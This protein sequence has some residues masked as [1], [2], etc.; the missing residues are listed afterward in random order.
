M[1]AD[2]GQFTTI[3]GDEVRE[4]KKCIVQ[5][6]TSENYVLR[7]SGSLQYEIRSLLKLCIE[8]PCHSS[9]YNTG[10]REFQLGRKHSLK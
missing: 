4:G 10:R 7:I 5:Q 3:A 2:V 9:K 1:T 8:Y 6:G